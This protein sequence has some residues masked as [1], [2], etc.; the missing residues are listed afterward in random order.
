MEDRNSR[1]SIDGIVAAYLPLVYNIVGWALN[2]HPHSA[3]VARKTILRAV[4]DPGDEVAFRP[5]LLASCVSQVR[6]A[7]QTA[8][9]PSRPAAFRPDGLPETD[10]VQFMAE[11]LGLAGEQLEIIEASR[12]LAGEDR[13]LLALWWQEA[14]GA[15]YRTELADALRLTCAVA[16]EAVARLVR[17]LEISRVVGRALRRGPSCPG[18]IAAAAGWDGKPAPGWRDRLAAHVLECPV[19]PP[20]RDELSPAEWLLG[21]LPLVPPPPAL[22]RD[23][24][25]DISRSTQRAGRV[26]HSAASDGSAQRPA[27][28]R[29][30]PVGGVKARLRRP[31]RSTLA[32]IAAAVAL[33]LAGGL[34]TAFRGTGSSGTALGPI[35]G[36]GTSQVEGAVQTFSLAEQKGVCT[37]AGEGVNL[38]LASSGTSWYYN[39]RPT[40]SGIVTPPGVTFVPMIKDSSDVTATIL[41]EVKQEGRYLLGFNEPDHK[42]GADMTVTQALDLWPKLEATGMLLGSPAVSF[43]T[44]SETS[45]LGQFMQG[46]RARGYRVDFVTVHWYGQHNWDNAAANVSELKNYLTQT[47]ALWGKP[48]WITELAL[49]NF[50]GGRHFPTEAQQAAFLTAVTKMLSTLHFVYRY[51]WYALSGSGAVKGTAPLYTNAAVVTAVGTAFKKAP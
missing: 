6:R 33:C 40:P 28:S 17:R 12:W 46:A 42:D 16:G 38:A 15:L 51:A 29:R 43:G 27:V 35:L 20:R 2:G 26:R 47:Y 34:V 45:W 23:L 37:T 5:R 14:G 7:G 48:I 9:M 1:D 49:V 50:Q 22:T 8:W 18:L 36:D 19:C 3:G 4:C 39:W 44:N 32:V 13:L 31:Q 24:I 21:E 30:P 25:S 11:R 41:N 10:F